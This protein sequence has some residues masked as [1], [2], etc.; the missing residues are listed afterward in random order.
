MSWIATSISN[1]GG[2]TGFDPAPVVPS[3]AVEGQRMTVVVS[4]SDNN[5][6]IAPTPPATET[7]T[8]ESS[9]NMP[10][11][12]TAA[13]SPCAVWIYGKDVSAD[14]ETNAGTK[15]Y[16]WTF[17]GSE[18][19]CAALFL[20]DAATF[21]QF[22]KNELSGTR[23]NIDAPTVTTTDDD[24]LVFHCAL[25]DGGAVFTGFPSGTTRASEIFG[26]TSGAGAAMGIVSAEFASPGATGVKNFTHANEESNGYTFSLVPSATA[27]R[28]QDSYRGYED[29]TESG[30]T[31][32]EAQ[33]TAFQVPPETTFHLRTGM[34]AVGDLAAESGELQTKE[35]GDNAFWYEK[36]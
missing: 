21:G 15:T 28:E 25:K 10:I 18:E 6:S 33:N 31:A 13:V 9:G 4:T 35:S 12:G 22:A 32:I 3:V 14:D 19:Q 23:T 26:A 34:Q 27:T 2:T 20:A 5:P 1:G 11:D 24:E 7:W 29:G 16:T 17:S 36:V 8:L 30:S